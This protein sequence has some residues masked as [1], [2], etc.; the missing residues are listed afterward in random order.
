MGEH[1]TP[2]PEPEKTVILF[3]FACRCER[4][5]RDFVASAR[6]FLRFFGLSVGAHRR[7]VYGVSQNIAS[8]N[9]QQR[10]TYGIAG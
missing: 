10:G 3:V 6:G 5:H 2:R 4:V 7:P 8:L 1:L 9:L